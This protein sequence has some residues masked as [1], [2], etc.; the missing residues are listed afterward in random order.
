MVLGL[1]P[2]PLLPLEVAHHLRLVAAKAVNNSSLL[3]VGVVLG[4]GEEHRLH[5]LPLLVGQ[6]RGRRGGT[7]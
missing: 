3:L 1:C 6:G 4:A 7:I 2:H 5:P